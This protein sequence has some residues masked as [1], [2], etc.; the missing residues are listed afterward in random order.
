MS[1]FTRK[2]RN[3]IYKRALSNYNNERWDVLCPCI[4]SDVGVSNDDVPEDFP[5]FAKFKPKK[6]INSFTRRGL[7]W[8]IDDRESRVRCLEICIA[9][10]EGEKKP[11]WKF[12]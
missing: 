1:Q 7:W 2:Q 6:L 8:P 3:E 12:W 4:G 10:T 9:Q 5:E 11:W